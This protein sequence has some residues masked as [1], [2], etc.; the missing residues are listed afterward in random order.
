MFNKFERIEDV[1]HHAK[2]T[3]FGMP[4]AKTIIESGHGGKMWVESEGRGKGATFYFVLPKRRGAG[5]A[6]RSALSGEK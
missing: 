1:K 5:T 2:G 6:V 3:G 4:I